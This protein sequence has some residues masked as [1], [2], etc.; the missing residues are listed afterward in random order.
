MNGTSNAA[1][2]SIILPPDGVQLKASALPGYT[3]AQAVCVACHSAEYMAYQ[4]PS[5]P[6]AYWEAMVLRMKM[7]P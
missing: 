7:S 6:R 5:A 1:E 2:K 3:K 4:P